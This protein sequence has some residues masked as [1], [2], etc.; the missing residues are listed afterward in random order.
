MYF[1]FSIT[2]VIDCLSEQRGL[3]NFNFIPSK[4]H[5]LIQTKQNRM[6]YIKL[7]NTRYA[8]SVF[9]KVDIKS[10]VQHTNLLIASL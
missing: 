9:T 1:Y 3:T 8:H 4:D 2:V 5:F 10:Q 7:P 6:V